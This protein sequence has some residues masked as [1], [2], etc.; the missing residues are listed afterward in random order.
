VGSVPSVP[1]GL[2][3]LSLA[4]KHCL[5]SPAK[6]AI[7]ECAEFMETFQAL[8]PEAQLGNR[9]LDLFPGCIVKHLAPKMSDDSY[10]DYIKQLDATL[11]SARQDVDT[12]HILSDASAPT[13]GAFQASLAAL[14]FRG[15]TKMAHIV[16]AGGRATAP[17]AELMALEMGISTALVVGCLSLI[18]FT[19]STMAMAD[20]VDL[21]PH[22]GQVSSL[23]VCSTLHKWF[24]EDHGRILHLWHVPSREEWK[25]HHEAHEAAK[26]AKIPLRPG[27]RVSFDFTQAAKE[28]AYWREWHKEFADT[29]RQG[30]GFLELVGLNGKPLKPTSSKGGAWS[31]FLASSSNSLMARVCRATIS[32]APMGEYCLRFHPGEPTHCWCPP[33]PLQTRDH[34]L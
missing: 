22:S 28:V 5:L 8:H 6:D 13:K 9:I 25:I 12:V 29:V 18:C 17:N 34:I 7:A 10:G 24:T 15:G 1:L 21:S 23:A 4:V 14:V 31:L 16:A 26:A 3:G 27:C 11:A 20:L 32:H 33:Q 30:R 2:V 19:D